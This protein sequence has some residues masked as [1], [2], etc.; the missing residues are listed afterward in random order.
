MT[1]PGG[2][3]WV[4]VT[5]STNADWAAG[6]AALA[7]A[8]DV[9][10]AVLRLIRGGP[11][12]G[13][14]G[15]RHG[16]LG[17][18]HGVLGPSRGVLGPPAAPFN[19]LG[20]LATRVDVRTGGHHPPHVAGIVTLVRALERAHG[21]VL[22]GAADGLLVPFGADGWTLVDVAQALTAPVVV[23]SGSSPGAAGHTAL[24]LDALTRRG[25][26]AAVLAVGDDILPVDL[27]GRIP[28][29]AVTRPDLIRA[30]AHGWLTPML[31][32]DGSRPPAAATAPPAGSAT[33]PPRPVVS[34]RQ[35]ALVLVSLFV[36]LA[37]ALWIVP[38]V[39]AQTVAREQRQDLT[40][41]AEAQRI[42]D[43]YH[44]V[45]PG[46]VDRSAH[47][48]PAWTEWIAG[49]EVPAPAPR[50]LREACPTNAPGVE[51]TVPGAAT[52]KRVNAAWLRIERWLAANAPVT[53]RA[54]GSPAPARDIADAQR[55]MSVSFPADVVASLRRHDGSDDQRD[56]SV[57]PGYQVLSVEEMIEDWGSIC[58]A[59]AEV[60]RTGADR[61][62]VPLASD[63]GDG[64]LV[65]DRTRNGRI[66]EYTREGGPSFENWPTSFAAL[67]EG[68]ATALET[69]APYIDGFFPR[70]EDGHLGWTLGQVVQ[71]PDA[72]R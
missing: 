3:P 25:S 23:V 41:W 65:A 50:P 8:S 9:P 19:A 32:A 43:P 18:G 38:L 63:H 67:L 60:P 58:S 55:H 54:L 14:L 28:A 15:P 45:A 47:P 22:V 29:A 17:P 33:V 69:G 46:P 64:L 4:V 2:G 70:V 44:R 62:F 72:G 48:A 12:H 20:G 36:V 53:Y 40:R 42:G 51:P 10:V 24:V 56:F 21:L 13:V 6:V 5:T 7:A 68:T 1:W 52:T 35:L 59:V 57:A 16:V 26:T 66:G 61:R 11:G 49:S 34:G 30:G 31:H 39:R 71:P 27:A 37:A